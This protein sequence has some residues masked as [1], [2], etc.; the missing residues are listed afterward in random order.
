MKRV[1]K[2]KKKKKKKKN[3]NTNSRKYPIVVNIQQSRNP[4]NRVKQFLKAMNQAS[5]VRHVY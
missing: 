3:E 5:H 1:W 2:Q 4:R